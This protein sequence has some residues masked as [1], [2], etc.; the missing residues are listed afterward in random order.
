MSER[1]IRPPD[2][3]IPANV[4]QTYMPIPGYEAVRRVVELAFRDAH[5]VLDLTY[6][7]GCFWR[8]PLPPGISVTSNNIDPAAD[9]TLHVDFRQ[10]GLP[11]QSFDLAVIDPPHLADGGATSIMATRYGTARG[12]PALVDLVVA[13]VAEAWRIAEVGV[14]VKVTDAAHAGE[15]VGLSDAVKA[16]LPVRPITVLHTYRAS[17]L[18]DRK[19]RAV[20]TPRSNGAI[21]LAFRREGHR[22]QDFQRLYERQQ[23]RVAA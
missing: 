18:V 1:R 23:R 13:G 20:R 3:A 16:A 12:T 15:V 19:W 22:H 8:D 4:T 6:A 10:T 14:L 7:A 9:T 11:A 2:P 21:W 5:T 17:G